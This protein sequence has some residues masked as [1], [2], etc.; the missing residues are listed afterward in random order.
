MFAGAGIFT[1]EMHPVS[2]LN[3]VVHAG[4]FDQS[5]LGTQE[6]DRQFRWQ[7]I[8]APA[9]LGAVPAYDRFFASIHGAEPL[10][11]GWNIPA[12]GRDPPAP[13]WADEKLMKKKRELEFQMNW[14][15]HGS[16]MADMR[17]AR[18]GYSHA[19]PQ[20]ANLSLVAIAMME[21]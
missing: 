1:T 19:P 20:Q 17:I 13:L 11:P 14:Q 7:G 2:D 16:D 9:D 15:T 5:K 21:K 18:S 12:P 3:S 4:A 10:E 8:P 6:Y